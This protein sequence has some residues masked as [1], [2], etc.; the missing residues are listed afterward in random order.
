MQIV[1]RADAGIDMG[2][3]HVMRCLTL[4]DHLSERGH[5][6]R[7]VCRERPGHMAVQIFTR[8]YN[9]SLLPPAAGRSGWLG[10]SEEVDAAATLAVLDGVPVNWFV[11]DNYA[12]GSAWE[13]QARKKAHHILS[14]DDLAD[15]S[16]DCDLLLDQTLG[17]DAADYAG[18]VPA[19]AT[20][21]VGAGMALLRSRFA[22]LRATLPDRRTGAIRR[23][24]VSLGGS[25]AGN[26]T[27]VVLEAIDRCAWPEGITVQIVLSSS[28]P[29]INTVR[30]QAAQ[31]PWPMEVVVDTPDMAELMARTDLAIGAAGTT[32]WE[33]CCLG[34]PT[35]VLIAAENQRQNA[36]ALVAAGA[37]IGLDA[38]EDLSHELQRALSGLI[39]RPTQVAGMSECA[40]GLVDGLGAQRVVAVMEA[41]S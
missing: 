32:S 8:G 18:L 11:T 28:N 16:H 37:A 25:D 34:L 39:A 29:W 23:L 38:S 41:L 14:I 7:F 24:L 33:R 17:R 3:G 5:R 13:R 36:A 2:I 27:T 19:G 4:A 9:V 1:F 22:Q 26:L 21:L 31:S 35:I 20:C 30:Q 15:R 40:A 12:I 10:V 6:C